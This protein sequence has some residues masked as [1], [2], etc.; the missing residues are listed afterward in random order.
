MHLLHSNNIRSPPYPFMFPVNYTLSWFDVE[1]RCRNVRVQLHE[2]VQ[3]DI[4]L[5][6]WPW[7]EFDHCRSLQKYVWKS[8]L[9]PCWLPG[10]ASEE[11]IAHYITIFKDGRLFQIQCTLGKWR[12]LSECSLS[13]QHTHWVFVFLYYYLL[14]AKNYFSSRER[15]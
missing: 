14:R 12:N 3:A 10:L 11:P 4:G 7:C 13:I 1:Q 8:G 15:K 6:V 2:N 5:T 9:L